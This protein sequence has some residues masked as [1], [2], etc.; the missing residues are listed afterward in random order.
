[1]GTL[2]NVH[3]EL[4]VSKGLSEYREKFYLSCVLSLRYHP[5]L[6]KY[7]CKHIENSPK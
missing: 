1:M 3:D 7:S 5:L 6:S 2:G 4:E